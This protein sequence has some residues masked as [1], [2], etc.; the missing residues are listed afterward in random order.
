MLLLSQQDPRGV[1]LQ[2]R[3]HRRRSRHLKTT[4]RRN[5]APAY[6]SRLP[7]PARSLD[8]FEEV[9]RKATAAKETVD[10][11]AV[12]VEAE[13]VVIVQREADARL[14]HAEREE[15]SKDEADRLALSAM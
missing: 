2:E 13:R 5:N 15:A 8:F 10:I 7:K 14:A 4:R 3:S 12:T 9:E 6:K 1:P 11:V